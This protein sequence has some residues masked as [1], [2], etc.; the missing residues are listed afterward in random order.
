ME[1]STKLADVW[2]TFVLA[3][4]LSNSLDLSCKPRIFANRT[5]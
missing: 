1:D 4:D 3:H 2:P 5:V